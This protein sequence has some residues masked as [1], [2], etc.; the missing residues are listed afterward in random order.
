MNKLILAVVSLTLFTGCFATVGVQDHIKV[1][2]ESAQVC[3]GHCASIGLELGAVAI[4]AS[5]VGCICQPK[6]EIA[7]KSASTAAG[8]ATI[9][10]QEQQRRN[11]Q[12][13]NNRH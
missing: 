9:M 3:K 11:D 8:M 4:M 13:R 7:S 10:L 5:N 12:N 1:P 2:P 6:S